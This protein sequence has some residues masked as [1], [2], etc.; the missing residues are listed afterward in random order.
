MA[1]PIYRCR[2]KVLPGTD[3][4]EVL[5]PARQ[6]FH[7]YEANTRRQ[8]HIRSPLFGKDKVFLAAFWEH[9][10]KKNRKDKTRRLKFYACALELITKATLRP[11]SQPY[12]DRQ[13]RLYRFRGRAADG[14]EFIVQISQN[15]N[16]R[17][18]FTSVFPQG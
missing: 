15:K 14:Q 1:E 4:A 11:E 9:L 18:Y 10:A 5:V 7:Q 2:N 13:A 17:K 16:G 3:Y 12:K 6:L 8:A